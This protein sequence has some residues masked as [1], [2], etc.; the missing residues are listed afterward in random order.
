MPWAG[1]WWKKKL[2]RLAAAAAPAVQ[3]CS[4]FPGGPG[5]RSRPGG[6][7]VRRERTA[8]GPESGEKDGHVGVVGEERVVSAHAPAPHGPRVAGPRPSQRRLGPGP[9][10]A[11]DSESVPVTRIV[12]WVGGC[13]RAGGQAG[14]RAGGRAGRVGGWQGVPG[15]GP[16]PDRPGERMAG[17]L[18]TGTPALRSAQGRE[19]GTERASAGGR[20]RPPGCSP[21]RP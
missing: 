18:H 14:G 12:R 16:G 10:P 6:G 8:P 7:G 1:L 5:R 19:R 20:G 9:G 2:R 11:T 4:W 21:G 13:G 3:R 17:W 15:D